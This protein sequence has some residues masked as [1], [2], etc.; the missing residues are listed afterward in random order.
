M[1]PKLFLILLFASNFS[2]AQQSLNTEQMARLADVGKVY[3]YIKYF[4][5][6]LQYKDI[7]WDSAFAANVE[8]IINAKNK[9]EYA[10]VIQKIFS[11][12]ND[13]LTTVANINSDGNNYHEQSLTYNVKDNILHIQMNDEPFM[14]TDEKLSEALQNLNNVKG[15]IIDM[16]RPVPRRKEFYF[17]TIGNTKSLM[18]INA[19]LSYPFTTGRPA[20]HYRSRLNSFK[21]N[22][23]KVTGNII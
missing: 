2:F 8:G 4:H 21:F 12:L 14:T 3:G 18:A 13:G 17:P 22:L 6:W 20:L 15:A 19:D 23:V 11:S 10:A 16:R 5:P 7:N 1:R 9:Q